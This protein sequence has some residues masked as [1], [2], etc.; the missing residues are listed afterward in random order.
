MS[1]TE[2]EQQVPMGEAVSPKGGLCVIGKATA[3]MIIV[4]RDCEKMT[5]I[6]A[7]MKSL[8]IV[9]QESSLHLHGLLCY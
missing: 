9:S 7:D 5:Q 2:Q 8:C 4:Q 3:T 6:F 1:E